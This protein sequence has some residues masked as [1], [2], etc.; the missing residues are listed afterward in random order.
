MN[1]N[2]IVPVGRA[3]YDSKNN[4]FV[5]VSTG[6]T[7]FYWKKFNL[8][9]YYDYDGEFHNENGPAR[10]FP[11]GRKEFWIHGKFIK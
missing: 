6:C 5:F 10:I 1:K 11:G 2:F 9:V 8:K 7:F 3:V 4:Y